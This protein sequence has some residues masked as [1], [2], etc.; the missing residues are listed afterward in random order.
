[1][2]VGWTA[3]LGVED[4]L[5]NNLTLKVEGLY[6]DLGQVTINNDEEGLVPL[7]GFWAKTKFAFSTVRAGLNW[8]V[9]WLSPH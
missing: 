8:K 6:T 7:P 3:G 1:M 4:A 9:D 5:T 2:R